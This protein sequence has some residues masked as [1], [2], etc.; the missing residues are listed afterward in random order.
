M[1][2]RD[3]RWVIP[4]ENDACSFLDAVRRKQ[5]LLWVAVIVWWAC[6]VAF[7]FLVNELFKTV[8]DSIV[9]VVFYGSALLLYIPAYKLFK[10]RCPYCNGTAGALP[11][12]RYRLMYCRS[13]GERI[14]CRNEEHKHAPTVP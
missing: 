7:V 2:L 3:Q 9:Y 6:V 5:R 13:C 4:L 1:L 10:L 11:I 12:F 14:E 8:P